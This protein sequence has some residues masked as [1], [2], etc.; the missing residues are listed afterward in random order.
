MREAAGLTQE[1]LAE[2]S[3]LAVTGIASLERGRRRAPTRTQCSR[4]PVRW[5]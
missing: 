5:D 3:G 2:R 4:S 1:E